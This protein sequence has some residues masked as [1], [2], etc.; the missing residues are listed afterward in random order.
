MFKDKKGGIILAKQ[1]LMFNYGHQL[2]Q[3]GD[4]AGPF[5]IVR[6]RTEAL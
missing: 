6:P 2:G 4:T 3:Q 5:S 1:G